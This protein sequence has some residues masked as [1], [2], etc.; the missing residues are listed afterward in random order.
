MGL[1]SFIKNEFID[2]IDWTSD[3]AQN[4]LVH[5]FVDKGNKIMNGAQLTVRETQLAILMNEGQFGDIY[6]PGLYT[7]T[8]NNMPIITTLQSWKYGFNSPF[9]VDVFFVSTAQFIDLKWGT[10][11]PILINDPKF[12][13]VRIRARGIYSVQVIDPKVFITQFSA[14]NPDVCINDI[15]GQLRHTI[16]NKLTAELGKANISVIDLAKNYTAVAE[17]I[18]PVLQKEFDK[19]GLKLVTFFIENIG[20][21]E[22]VEAF[23]DKVSQM[24]MVDNMKTFTQFQTAVSIEKAAENENGAA[25][26]FVGMGTGVS[27]QNVMGNNMAEA[28][29]NTAND[30]ATPEQVMSLIKQLA[31]MKEKGILSEEEFA[32]KKADLLKRI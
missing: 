5:K 26:A 16:I 8:T 30:T 25:G 14:S 4:V 17:E 18:M 3:D 10:Q 1:F 9:K 28:Q 6:T 11:T 32:A 29:Q 15:E 20:L 31:E 22:E 12:K 27:M 2:V 13:Q 19:F 7:L 24:N 23:V 21:P